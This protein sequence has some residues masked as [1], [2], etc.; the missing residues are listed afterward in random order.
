MKRI[1]KAG[2]EKLLKA[3][4]GTPSKEKQAW[5]AKFS[6]DPCAAGSRRRRATAAG[7]E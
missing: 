4:R 5:A 6:L 2:D 3:W 7:H 1:E